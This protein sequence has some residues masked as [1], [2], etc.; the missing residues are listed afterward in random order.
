MIVNNWYVFFDF[1]NWRDCSSEHDWDGGKVLWYY[2][3][4]NHYCISIDSQPFIF[5]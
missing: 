4:E 3:K 2:L 5:S 1:Q